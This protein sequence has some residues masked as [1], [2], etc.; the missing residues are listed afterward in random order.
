MTS[1][2]CPKKTVVI[3]RHGNKEGDALSPLGIAQIT[4]LANFLATFG[5]HF[6]AAYWS[7]AQRTL[8]SI[9]VVAETLGLNRMLPIRD[10]RAGM[11]DMLAA[12]SAGFMA[13]FKEASAKI[14]QICDPGPATVAEYLA[15]WP[16]ATLLK[17]RLE[18]LMQEAIADLNPGEAVI[19]GSHGPTAELAVLN[20]EACAALA[21]GDAIIY[22]FD[23]DGNMIASC[24]ITNPLS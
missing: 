14:K 13:E 12:D 16:T 24:R 22:S 20:P 3:I 15:Y 7:G 23:M 21:E 17:D 9:Q 8:Q 6:V 18:S 5:L 11:E 1:P 10:E 4:A 2:T 19:I